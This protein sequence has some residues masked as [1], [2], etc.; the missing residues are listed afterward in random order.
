M[1]FARPVSL[2]LAAVAVVSLAACGDEDAGD[3]VVNVTVY[4]ESF[5]EDGIPA[6]EMD[7]GWSVQFDRFTV[8]I[9]DVVVAGQALPDPAPV[10]IST[11]TAGAGSPLGA[12]TVPAGAHGDASFRI[13]RVEVE[14]FAT[15]GDQSV[16]FD[17]VFDTSVHYTG[18]ETT[19]TVPDGG[20][21]TFQIT[22][23]ADHLFYDSLV[24]EEPALRF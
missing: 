5:I 12:L 22:V 24:S 3:G 6:D 20:E 13:A 18:C 23:H 21:A 9:E 4:G 11:P 2:S 7:D 8:T 1:R 14:G 17:W 10:D 19:T 16:A 15:A